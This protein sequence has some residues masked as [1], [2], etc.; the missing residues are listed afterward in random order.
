MAASRKLR[1]EDVKRW[2]DTFAKQFV[3]MT[4]VERNRA[5]A[6][7]LNKALNQALDGASAA[8][9][10]R[11]GI[12]DRDVAYARSNKDFKNFTVQRVVSAV[13]AYIDYIATAELTPMPTPTPTPS[14][15]ATS[16]VVT[17]TIEPTP[18]KQANATVSESAPVPTPS[19]LADPAAPTSPLVAPVAKVTTKTSNLGWDAT[20]KDFWK[21]VDASGLSDIEVRDR[22]FADMS[23]GSWNKLVEHRSGTTPRSYAPTQDRVARV[24]PKLRELVA[25]GGAD[26]QPSHEQSTD[27]RAI[28]APE[29]T[30]AAPVNTPTRPTPPAAN[31]S[32]NRNWDTTF[33]E[34]WD[35]AER[36][37]MDAAAVRKAFFGDMSGSAWNSL[38][39]NRG[40]VA[41]TA[42]GK[43]RA[44]V[45]EAVDALRAQ[46][47]S[48]EPAPNA[49]RAAMR[50]S[51]RAPRATAPRPTPAAPIASTTIFPAQ[52]PI[53]SAAQEEL[54]TRVADDLRAQHGTILQ[55]ENDM[56]VISLY[57]DPR[58]AKIVLRNELDAIVESHRAGMISELPRWVQ[59]MISDDLAELNPKVILQSA[60]QR[61][62]LAIEPIGAAG[63]RVV[64]SR[65]IAG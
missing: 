36:A 51:V 7:E 1:K 18:T 32:V 13:N 60:L 42:Y 50:P 10:R 55:G 25:R 62:E 12:S 46:V 47:R 21:L 15:P 19:E 52:D 22:Y 24:I 39:R 26:P 30:E 54:V 27:P 48:A 6:A 43:T 31:K 20:L 40:G 44:R 37:G 16:E 33:T 29:T 49:P 8:L 45:E 38:L 2:L 4:P 23:P 11:R 59:G 9:S 63:D 61:A 5:I 3:D 64:L 58:L 65:A 35:L 28:E 34:L 14:A 41:P 57:T 17:S 56:L 53:S